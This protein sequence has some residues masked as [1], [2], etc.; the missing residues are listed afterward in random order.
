MRERLK[1]RISVICVNVRI[2]V[3]SCGLTL[4]LRPIP[5]DSL[6]VS[7]EVASRSPSLLR[8]DYTLVARL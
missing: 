5:E 4:S 7:L 1:W 6:D 8:S 3:T 2:L